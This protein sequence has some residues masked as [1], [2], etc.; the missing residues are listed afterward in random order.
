MGLNPILRPHSVS[1]RL[2]R[3][4]VFVLPPDLPPG[5]VIKLNCGRSRRGKHLVFWLPEGTK[6]KNEAIDEVATASSGSAPP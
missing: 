1:L 5:S 6:I 2:T 3:Q 4:T